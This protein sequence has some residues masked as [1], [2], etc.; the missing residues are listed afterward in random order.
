MKRRKR[1][2]ADI[3][4]CESVDIKSY[5]KSV[6]LFGKARVPVKVRDKQ[7]QE[8]EHQQGQTMLEVPRKLANDDGLSCRERKKDVSFECEAQRIG[9]S[10]T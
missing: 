8:N 6:G 9:G 5:P 4:W 3:T 10:D 2:L 7:K 1:L